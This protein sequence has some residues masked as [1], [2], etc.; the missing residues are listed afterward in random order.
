LQ[1]SAEDRNTS[2]IKKSQNFEEIEFKERWPIYH[3][4]NWK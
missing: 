1:G 3:Q 4:R 2:N